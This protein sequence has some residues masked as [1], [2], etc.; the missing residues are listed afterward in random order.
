MALV[1]DN[2]LRVVYVW[3]LFLVSTLEELWFWSFQR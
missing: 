3:L 2:D 1:I